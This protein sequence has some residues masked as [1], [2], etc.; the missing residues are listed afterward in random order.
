M[1]LKEG[2]R[3][4][5]FLDKLMKDAAYYVSTPINCLK[6]TKNHKKSKANPDAEDLLEDVKNTSEFRIDD[7]VMFMDWLAKQREKLTEAI[8]KTKHSLSIDIDAYIESNKFSRLMQNS[9]S[10]ALSVK[11]YEK[12]EQGRDYKFNAEG[13][14]TPYYY[15]I[16]SVAVDSYDRDKIK[17]MLRLAAKMSDCRSSEVDYAMVSATVEYTPIYDVNDSFEDVMTDFVKRIENFE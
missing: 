7:V 12:I 14:Q 2:F 8:N 3:Y 6:I 17:Q 5:S 11:P 10:Q 13:N 16:E 1:N 9:I 4:Q 15:D